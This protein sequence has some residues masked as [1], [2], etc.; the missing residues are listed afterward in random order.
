[1]TNSEFNSV[2]EEIA[3][4]LEARVGNVS[5]VRAYGHAARAIR[6]LRRPASTIFDG[7][8]EECQTL[9]VTLS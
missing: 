9:P 5:Y 1:M 8:S 6:N 2:L 4:M 3:A 7:G